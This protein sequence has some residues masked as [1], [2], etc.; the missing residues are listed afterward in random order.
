MQL[1]VVTT[2]FKSEIYLD[3][4]LREIMNS[5]TYLRTREFELIFVLD[6]ITD[7][8]KELLLKKQIEIPQIKII[9]LSRNFGHHY[10]ITAGLS[11]AKGDK[12]FLIDC[13]LEV[14]PSVLI[15]FDEVLCKTFADVVYGYQKKRKGNIIE[16]E[17]GGLFWKLFNKFSEIKIPHNVVTERL[18]TKLYVDSLITLGDK[19]LFLGGMMYWIGFIQVPIEVNKK[20]RVGKSSYNISRRIN[21]LIEAVTSFSETP[22]KMIFKTGIIITFIS[23]S[24]AL[25]LILRK[26]MNPDTILMGYT[27]I[28]TILLFSLGIITSSLGIVGIYIARI[29]K[30]SQN[31][32]NYI[33]KKIY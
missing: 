20:Q 7:N 21:L 16:R 26:I 3:E 1:S 32:P 24:I 8:S 27:S 23:L 2:I 29:F 10:A 6:G 15:D 22:L 31:R 30:Q 4:F 11:L 9:E 18:M 5:I 17:L 28:I 14:S 13:D 12:V 25:F 33:I 19:N